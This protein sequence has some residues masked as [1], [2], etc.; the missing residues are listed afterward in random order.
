MTLQ[1][2][3]N[4]FIINHKH[5]SIIRLDSDKK[6]TLIKISNLY[7]FNRNFSA[8]QSHNQQS[9]NSFI[10]LTIFV[11]KFQLNF[12]IGYSKKYRR[13]RTLDLQSIIKND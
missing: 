12:S 1:A 10:Y 3:G 7:T 4:D 8:D 11:E 13:F 9:I 5:L 2:V 6:I